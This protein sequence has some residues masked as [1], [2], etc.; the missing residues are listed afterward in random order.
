MGSLWSV[1]NDLFCAPQVIPGTD[2][3]DLEGDAEETWKKI[4]ACLC[5]IANETDPAKKE[6]MQDNLAK[7]LT[8]C[9]EK[10]NKNASV[11][12]Q[13]RALGF[14]ARL[15]YFGGTVS[16]EHIEDL[17]SIKYQ[18]CLSEIDDFCAE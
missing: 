3:H 1:A 12:D 8:G 6:K 18:E 11:A 14:P 9:A 4:L 17:T 2:P 15:V 16:D 13:K 10:W 5:K 7:N